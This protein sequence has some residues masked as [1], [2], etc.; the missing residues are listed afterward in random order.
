MDAER[1]LEEQLGRSRER[2]LRR[3]ADFL[4]GR[5]THS[6]ATR[7][8][9]FADVRDFLLWCAERDLEPE[10]A[11]PADLE[12]WHE[13]ALGRYGPA[14][15]QRKIAAV[16][17]FFG[18]LQEHGGREDDPTGL[19]APPR[20]NKDLPDFLT[21]KE[22]RRLLAALPGGE[23]ALVARDRALLLLFYA[24]G[25]RRAEAASLDW[26][27][28]DTR[29]RL[30]RVQ[31]KGGKERIVPI[32]R[33]ALAAL[34]TYR[35]LWRR[36]E[37]PRRDREA[38]FLNRRGDRLSVRSINRIVAA[39]REE[40][41]AG[42][43]LHPHMLRHSFASHLLARGADLRLIQELLGHASLSTTQRYTHLDIET[44]RGVYDR[45]HP[46]AR[47]GCRKDESLTLFTS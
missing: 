28:I 34:T 14:G 9:Y 25:V 4:T 18:F 3:Y 33:A 20:R 36:E 21:E 12:R 1:S 5:A 30:L 37:L 13:E 24:T 2:W 23:S 8:A 47:H 29:R 41:G 16:R 17:S 11:T 10:K 39:A 38:V 7:N 32:A 46:H 26:S 31:G 42:S 44:L 19:L 45:T 22:A 6:P 35:E 15:Q 40:E 43:M 27:R